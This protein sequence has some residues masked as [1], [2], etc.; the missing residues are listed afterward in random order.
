MTGPRGDEIK[1]C[2]SRGF[3]SPKNEMF[4]DVGLESI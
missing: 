1:I 3:Y 2:I 4:P